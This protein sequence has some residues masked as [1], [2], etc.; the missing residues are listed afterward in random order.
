MLL[1]SRIGHFLKILHVQ[2]ENRNDEDSYCEKR[3][4]NS[5]KAVSSYSFFTRYRK[6]LDRINVP[7]IFIHMKTRGSLL[8]HIA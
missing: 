2:R 7:A 1:I 8:L 6:L 3:G 4:T 5:A